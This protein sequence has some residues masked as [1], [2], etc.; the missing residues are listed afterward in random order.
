MRI[1]APYQFRAAIS[2]HM[3]SHNVQ[4]RQSQAIMDVPDIDRTCKRLLPPSPSYDH[5]HLYHHDLHPAPNSVQWERTP[6]TGPARSCTDDLLGSAPPSTSTSVNCKTQLFG[7]SRV[8]LYSVPQKLSPTPRGF[9][10]YGVCE[11]PCGAFRNSF[12]IC[13]VLF[14]RGCARVNDV[15]MG[16]AVCGSEYIFI[17]PRW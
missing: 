5:T 13:A 2:S 11:S 12:S 14:G 6:P 4:P 9:L 10:E 3:L 16:L 15:P 17:W 1:Q 7:S 8:G